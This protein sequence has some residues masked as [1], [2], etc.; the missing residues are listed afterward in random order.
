MSKQIRPITALLKKGVHFLFTPNIEAIVREM[1]AE[2][3]ASPVAVFPDW[4]AVEDGSR[5]FRG[6]CDASIDGF[7]ATLGQEQPDGSVW[8]SAYVSRATLDSE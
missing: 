1:L 7:G 4:N 6:C 2:L 3:A 5:S 8:P